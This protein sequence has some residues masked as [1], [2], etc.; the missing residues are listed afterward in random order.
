VKLY[1]GRRGRELVVGDDFDPNDKF[2]FRTDVILMDDR[3]AI[4]PTL[5]F[6]GDVPL[7]R[8]EVAE[9]R[10]RLTAWL[11]TGSLRIEGDEV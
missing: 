1:V 3:C 9:L 11:E 5:T 8:A 6:F 2:H 10:D 7:S 4:A